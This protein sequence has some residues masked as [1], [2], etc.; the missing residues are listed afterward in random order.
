MKKMRFVASCSNRGRNTSKTVV[1]PVPEE[2]AEHM[3]K[4][5]QEK[6]KLEEQGDTNL[7]DMKGFVSEGSK[8]MKIY[9]SIVD[10]DGSF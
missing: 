6:K 9:L 3:K 4:L 1:F 2:F 7:D 5:F 8:Q 10:E